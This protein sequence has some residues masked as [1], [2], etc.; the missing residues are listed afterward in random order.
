MPSV[1]LAAHCEAQA[2]D[3]SENEVGSL[4][5]GECVWGPDIGGLPDHELISESDTSGSEE[6]LDNSSGPAV[7][8]S[9][10]RRAVDVGMA[11][12]QL[13]SAWLQPGVS[14][15]DGDEAA[16]FGDYVSKVSARRCGCNLRC[17]E[18]LVEDPDF[19]NGA[20]ASWLHMVRAPKEVQ[21]IALHQQFRGEG[22]RVRY[23]LLGKPLCKRALKY[24]MRVGS[25]RLD[26][27][28]NGAPDLRKGPVVK[29]V[30]RPG[31]KASADVFSFLWG[32]YSSIAEF[33]PNQNVPGIVGTDAL[34]RQDILAATMLLDV[35]PVDASAVQR[36]LQAMGS[37]PRKCLPPGHPKEY[38]WQFLGKRAPRGPGSA[39]ALVP[40]VLPN[41][42]AQALVLEAAGEPHP[43]S[44]VSGVSGLGHAA[45][46]TVF[47]RVWRK[48][49]RQLLGFTKFQRH[50]VC[51]S[52]SEL[53]AKIRTA[54]NA[55][56]R[57][58]W[59]KKYDEHNENQM[60]DR[61]IYYKVREQSR[62]GQVVCIMQDGSDQSKYRIVRVVET[63][64]E[65]EGAWCPRMKLLG[66]WAHGYIGCFWLLEEDVQRSGPDLTL[67]ALMSTIEEV[68]RECVGRG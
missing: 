27:V 22:C 51:N 53:K 48:H 54:A 5:L 29:H 39:E 36:S 26:R 65:F 23:T 37:L 58:H 15:G 45:S 2:D 34:A 56:E 11:C 57:V 10:K 1:A 41:P 25:H 32:I 44:L 68:R 17:M 14:V 33:S 55:Q 28:Q 9:C 43:L 62:R 47:K 3:I 30:E 59:A 38:Y 12:S 35:N 52:C 6:E 20:F 13:P 24:F 46:Y 31:C 63:P 40:P 67:E 61:Q 4:P 49:F 16:L 60:S 66:S 19:V 21:D 7:R 18:T 50:C 42:A 8:E 64:K